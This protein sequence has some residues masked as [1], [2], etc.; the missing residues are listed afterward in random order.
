MHQGPDAD[1]ITL[2]C[3]AT[4]RAVPKRFF[5]RGGSLFVTGFVVINPQRIARAK[6]LD[7]T[8]AMFRTVFADSGRGDLVLRCRP[9]CSESR[10]HSRPMERSNFAQGHLQQVRSE[11]SGLL[12]VAFHCFGCKFLIDVLCEEL[13]KEQGK[14]RGR[15]CGNAGTGFF[16]FNPLLLLDSP[17]CLGVLGLTFRRE[18]G[19]GNPAAIPARRP[20]EAEHEAPFDGSASISMFVCRHQ[21]TTFTSGCGTNPL[22]D[23]MP[24]VPSHA[25]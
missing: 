10:F 9:P 2:V 11:V 20:G 3:C 6:A 4:V 18:P 17:T 14:C 5:T 23:R 12:V 19:F 22:P 1:S 8:P 7:M 15:F 25:S 13:L 21:F 24:Q 16:E